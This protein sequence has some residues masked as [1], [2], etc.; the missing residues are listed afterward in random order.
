M[1]KK[2]IQN[3]K[4]ELFRL[5]KKQ[6]SKKYIE[7]NIL[8][9][10]EYIVN[11]NKKKIL[12]SGS[13]GI[14]KSTLVNI[15][16]NNIEKYYK[17][18][19]IA[20]KLDDYYLSKAERLKLSKKNHH[21][22]KTRG[23]PGTHN[24]KKLKKN[25]DDFEK[26]RY[27]IYIPIFDKLIDDRL[28]KTRIEKNVQDILILEGWCCGCPPLEKKFLHKNINKLE[29]NEDK[30]RVWRDYFNQNLKHGYKSLFEI[31]D[32][33]IFLKAPSFNFVL[34][35]RLKQEEMNYSNQKNK[36]K[37][38]EKEISYFISHYEKITKWM[39]KKLP[40]IAHLVLIINKRQQI[41][42]INYN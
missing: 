12:I 20:L 31:F 28:L 22:L 9:I 29:A 33:I 36:K 21:L 18:K 16:K 37:M 13:Q 10:I 40:N 27:P 17:K 1:K 6:F 41:T 8:P 32:T 35:W 7:S 23:V 4:T 26:S 3:I 25:I 14:G 19:I 15:L 39:I 42:K 34:N 11:S 5:T 30:E 24:L 38:N 2:I